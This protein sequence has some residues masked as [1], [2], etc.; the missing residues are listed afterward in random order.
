MNTTPVAYFLTK[1]KVPILLIF[2]PIS[3]SI[4]F[5]FQSVYKLSL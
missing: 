5:S 2:S 3:G 4:S 1:I